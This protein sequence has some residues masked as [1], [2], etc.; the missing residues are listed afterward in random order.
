MELR[1]SMKQKIGEEV[2]RVG[3]MWEANN[4]AKRKMKQALR[5]KAS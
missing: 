1:C 3:I 5:G 4:I 2:D